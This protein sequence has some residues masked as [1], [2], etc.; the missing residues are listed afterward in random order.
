MAASGHLGLKPCQYRPVQLPGSCCHERKAFC[1]AGDM[2]QAFSMLV[3]DGPP[4]FEHNTQRGQERL[5]GNHITDI[6]ISVVSSTCD[7]YYIYRRTACTPNFAER[8]WNCNQL[9]QDF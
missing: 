6:Y 4:G 2:A 9:P 3:A 8:G 5:G 1:Q 7:I